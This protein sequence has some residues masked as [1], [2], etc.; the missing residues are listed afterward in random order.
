ME[1]AP[2]PQFDGKH[3]HEALYSPLDS[4]KYERG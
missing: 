4:L 1:A 2:Y 3:A